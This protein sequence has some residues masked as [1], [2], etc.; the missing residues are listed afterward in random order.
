MSEQLSASNVER[1]AIFKLVKWTSN[2][3]L[4]DGGI[5]SRVG[6]LMEIKNCCD[7]SYWIPGQ[8]GTCQL[9][10]ENWWF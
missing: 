5:V 9:P 7:D 1:P 4:L 2:T 10:A 8:P 6:N 3:L